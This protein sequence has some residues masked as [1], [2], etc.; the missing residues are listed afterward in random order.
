MR[1]RL[2]I[3]TAVFIVAAFV[4]FGT[5][6]EAQVTLVSY[7]GQEAAKASLPLSLEVPPGIPLQLARFA[8]SQPR[9]FQGYQYT[10]QNSGDRPIVAL[11]IQWKYYVAGKPSVSALNRADFWLAG[12]KGWLAPGQERDFYL[13]GMITKGGELASHVVGVPVYVEFDDGTRLGSEADTLFPEIASAR[14]AFVAECQHALTV[15]DGSGKQALSLELIHAESSPP[16]EMGRRAAGGM[17]LSK[18]RKG[19]LQAVVAELKRISSLKVT[20]Y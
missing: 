15:Y 11:A 6:A 3:G 13:G 16:A 9:P 5:W 19:G 12:P 18:W 14:R 8:T 20:G 2:T 1:K 17:L 10:L 4:F 7:T